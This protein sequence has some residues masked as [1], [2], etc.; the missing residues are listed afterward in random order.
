MESH[1]HLFSGEQPLLHDNVFGC[2]VF[3]LC[4]QLDDT[5][6]TPVEETTTGMN[7]LEWYL[8]VLVPRVGHFSDGSVSVTL[9]WTRIHHVIHVTQKNRIVFRCREETRICVIFVK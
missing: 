8:N 2:V 5:S 9:V 3:A 6:K 7:G 4:Q 1:R